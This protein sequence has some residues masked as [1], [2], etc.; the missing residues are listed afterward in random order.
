MN[1]R[2]GIDSYLL[3]VLA[4]LLEERN[5]SKTAQRL[6]QTQ[7]AI[8]TALKRLR[9]LTGDELLVRGKSGMVPTDYALS[10]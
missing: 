2:E 5:V 7:P 8:S 3:R 1:K 10:L 9:T 4:T 6:G